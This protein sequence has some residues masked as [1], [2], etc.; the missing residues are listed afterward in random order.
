MK[1]KI[2]AITVGII[3]GAISYWFNSY[4]VMTVMGIH[5][6]LLLSLGCFLGT[7]LLCIFLNENASKLM[8]FVCLGVLFAIIGRIF[9][10][11]IHDSTSHNLFIFEI[12][13]AMTITIL[14]AL[15]GSYFAQL[16]KP[17]KSK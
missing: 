11:I 12:I 4:N 13:I 17:L 2:F 15:A 6:F 9:F 16:F 5:I 3:A 8:L 14:S 10:D 1:N 7:F